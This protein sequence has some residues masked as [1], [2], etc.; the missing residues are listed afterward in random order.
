MLAAFMQLVFL[1]L[2]AIYVLVFRENT[3][4]IQSKQTVT[5]YLLSQNLTAY[6][7]KKIRIEYGR[8]MK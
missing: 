3:A 7:M 1:Q 2:Y 5:E 8:C 4:R 6:F